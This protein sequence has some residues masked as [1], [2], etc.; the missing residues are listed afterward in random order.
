MYD[1]HYISLARSLKDIRKRLSH[2]EERKLDR[3]FQQY[4]I[5]YEA[6]CKEGQREVVKK[7]ITE[8]E[9]K[10]RRVNFAIERI[11]VLIGPHY[12]EDANLM[13]KNVKAE[14]A[15]Y[16]EAQDEQHRAIS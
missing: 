6:L 5:D 15:Q 7:I 8:E 10:K 14:M 11:A 2:K 16:M 13:I 9:F 12:G 3:D 4:A 1:P